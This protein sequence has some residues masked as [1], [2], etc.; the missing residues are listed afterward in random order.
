M[1]TKP[2]IPQHQ[3]LGFYF[4]R[5]IYFYSKDPQRE[6]DRKRERERFS[7]CYFTPE[8]ATMAMPKPG[9]WNSN[10]ISHVGEYLGLLPLLNQVHYQGTWTSRMPWWGSN[11]ECW[12]CRLWLNVLCHITGL[13]HTAFIST[14]RASVSHKAHCF[15]LPVAF[16]IHS[17]CPSL[18]L[19]LSWLT[20]IFEIQFTS[21]SHST[22]IC[23]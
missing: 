9:A 1:T 17:L 20:L 18:V 5:I 22:H 2:I 8:R 13:L 7:I 4:S 3:L 6:R 14:S 15:L 11:V 10:Q 23:F 21:H 19:H 12:C 16:D